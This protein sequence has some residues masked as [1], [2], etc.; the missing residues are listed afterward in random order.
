VKANVGLLL[1]IESDF[2]DEVVGAKVVHESIQLVEGQLRPA[3]WRG[4]LM[5][6]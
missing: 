2:G 1:T 3:V 6:E 4:E 5:C